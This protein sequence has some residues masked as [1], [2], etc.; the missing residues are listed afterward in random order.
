MDILYYIYNLKQVF[1]LFHIRF[2]LYYIILFIIYYRYY[3]N[4]I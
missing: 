4:G 3:R 2:R 1:L